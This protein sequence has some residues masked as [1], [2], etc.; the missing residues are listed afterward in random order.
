MSSVRRERVP[1]IDTSAVFPRAVWHLPDDVLGLDP[2]ASG[3][4]PGQALPPGQPSVSPFP[5]RCD[6]TEGWPGPHSRSP[7]SNG[8][9][10]VLKMLSCHIPAGQFI[11]H[12][13][14]L[15]P[16][17]LLPRRVPSHY[18]PPA[19]SG[20]SA[21]LHGGMTDQTDADTVGC[22]GAAVGANV[23]D[24]GEYAGR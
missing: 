19:H 10:A 9:Y 16:H 21:G 11:V 8:T 15:T 17:G 3:P 18:P 4:P 22:R 2:L 13:E 20:R 12:Q 23:A 1:M 24:R 5:G 6:P 7:T 14:S